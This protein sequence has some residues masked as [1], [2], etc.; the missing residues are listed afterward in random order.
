[1]KFQIYY[2]KI[3]I[4]TI[5]ISLMY[6]FAEEPT[7]KTAAES[8]A[9]YY[10][11]KLKDFKSSIIAL[12]KIEETGVS[13]EGLKET[14]LACRAAFKYNEFLLNYVDNFKSK[15]FNAA[16]LVVSSYVVTAEEELKK[17][18]GLQVMEDLIYNPSEG[19]RAELQNEIKLLKELVE[20]ELNRLEKNDI[21]N[22][23]QFNII[24]LDALRVEI[25]RLEALGI[26]GF[27]VPDSQNS[28][29]EA[30]ANLEA[31]KKI[32]S[33]Y[34]PLLVKNNMSVFYLNGE[35]KIKGAINYLKQN[36][37]FIELDRLHFI[38]TYL[39]PI[40]TWLNTIT[41]NLEY[42]Y[43]SNANAFD[44]DADYLFAPN[45]LNKLFFAPV[46][47]EHTFALG[48]KL[49][50]EKL[51]S[52]NRTR[53]CATC[54][55]PDLAFADGM[56]KN[57]SIDSSEILLRNTPSLINVAFQTRFFYDS[58]STTLERQSLEVI[59]N[60]LEMGVNL[61]T[62]IDTLKQIPEYNSLF[63]KAFVGEVNA[64]KLATS[65]AEY[66]SSI[67]STNSKLD[68]YFAGD[69]SALNQSEKNGFNIFSGKAKCATC[70]FYPMFNGLVPPHY[71]DTES[72]ILGTPAT[73]EKQN[74]ID[75]DK[76][77]FNATGLSIHEF[78]FKTPGLR[79][80]ELTAPY[81][82]NG[83]FETL[84][85]VVEFYNNGGGVG[86]GMDLPLQTLSSDSLNLTEQ[87][88]VDLVNFMKALTDEKYLVY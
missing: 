19:S 30:I 50:N 88:K 36:N 39:H 71:T 21:G 55:S 38:D 77:R 76:G 78:A 87:E 44:R 84:E 47:S 3:L 18:H 34:K 80:V 60:K 82:H 62:V 24:I 35:E 27:D 29:P 26:V 49:F 43:P 73:K 67:T 31:L 85:E 4:V 66:V 23:K 5:I 68:R 28:I 13:E 69:K 22:A 2:V 11:A 51:L 9:S 33:F 59:H 83:V 12:E 16:N 17:P 1:M 48:E 86:Q 57:I 10:E 70:H 53:S 61:E 46:Q 41:K 42:K 40:S 15:K 75:A 7:E 74:I 20:K 52:S 32:M 79:N 72:E 56:I 65:I 54:H 45:A 37:D 25:Y 6:S 58:K 64:Y 63:D 8:I 81:M 14:F